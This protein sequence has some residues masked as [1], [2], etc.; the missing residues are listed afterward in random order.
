[1]STLITDNVNTG[2]I[3]NSTGNTT[4]ISIDSGGR[5]GLSQN[6]VET[7]AL[8]GSITAPA[9]DNI[10]GDTTNSTWRKVTSVPFADRGGNMVVDNSNGRFTFPHAGVF[11]VMC[12]L[13]I[14]G[15]DATDNN[16]QTEIHYSTDSGSNFSAVGLQARGGN[17]RASGA[18]TL[19][20]EAMFNVTN[21]STFRLRINL[22]S[23]TGVNCT[24]GNSDD[25]I[26]TKII[27]QQI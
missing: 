4:A 20:N 1:M 22:G 27:F 26:Y 25:A 15:D 21:S 6:L 11:R 19:V 3:K 10:I 13:N 17:Y 9:S 16:V 12:Q 2:T 24:G 7:W 5:V 14:V 23:A 8:N 18:Y